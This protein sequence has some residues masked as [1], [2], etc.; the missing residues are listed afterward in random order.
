MY[1]TE[2]PF[3]KHHMVINYLIHT[4]FPDFPEHVH[5]SPSYRQNIFKIILK[6]FLYNARSSFGR[7]SFILY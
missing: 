5:K 7:S 2:K 6:Y 4:N 3:F 1:N